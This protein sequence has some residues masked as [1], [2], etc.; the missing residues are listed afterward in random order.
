MKKIII[1]AGNG[2]LPYNVAKELEKRKL[3]FFII[4]FKNNK[5]SAK[6]KKY[7]PI[8]INFGKIVTELKKL[9]IKKFDSIIM[10]GGVKKPKL[11]ELKP[12]FNS[13]KLIPMFTKKIIEGGDNNLLSF[14]IKKIEEIGFK[15]INIKD[16]LPELFLGKG[17]FTKI[18][19]KKDMIKDIK[20]GQKILEHISKF[21]IGQ[22]IIIQKG[23]VVGIE[24]VQG[25]DF[26]IKNSKNYLVNDTNA[27]LVKSTKQKQDLRVDLPTVGIKTMKNCKKSNIYGL[28]F[29]ANNTIF[30]DVKRIISYCN[31][32]KL[33]LI[34]V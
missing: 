3:D 17:V 18:L 34:G 22:S 27:I 5:V 19:P 6:L 30:L 32:N 1:L 9:K 8:E 23:N 2:E 28:A 25:T 12:D 21:D 26:L 33:F 11:K 24:G 10:I 13:L 31:E 29:T 14:C 15:I 20:K 4:T 16:V 7:N